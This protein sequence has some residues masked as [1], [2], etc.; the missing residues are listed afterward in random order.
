MIN[1]RKLLV[2]IIVWAVS[3]MTIA[4]LIGGLNIPRFW[5]I[6]QH[7][8]KEIGIVVGK[9]PHDHQSL[10]YT[11]VVNKVEYSSSTSI[12]GNENPEYNSIEIGKTIIVYFDTMNPSNSILREPKRAI[13]SEIATVLIAGLVGSIFIAFYAYFY[14]LSKI[15]KILSKILQYLSQEK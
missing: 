9:Y 13:S 1:K 4:T 10:K 6:N 12:I 11:Y 2:S 14:A 5:A 7:P 15:Q 3:F 8:G